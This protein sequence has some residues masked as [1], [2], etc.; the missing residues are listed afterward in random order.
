MLFPSVV[1]IISPLA[2]AKRF[3]YRTNGMDDLED[4]L[5]QA[6]TA[7]TPEQILFAIEKFVKV[8]QVLGAI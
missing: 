7:H 6:R 8:G 5:V 4:Q 3:V 2:K 1:Q